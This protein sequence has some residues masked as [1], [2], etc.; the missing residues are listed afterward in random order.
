MFVK[1]KDEKNTLFRYVVHGHGLQAFWKSFPQSQKNGREPTR[2]VA[3]DIVN[4]FLGTLSTVKMRRSQQE[5]STFRS[6]GR[7]TGLSNIFAKILS[8]IFVKVHA[9]FRSSK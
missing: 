5:S 7:P 8:L 4:I 6:V 9:G 2:L 3:S 1:K